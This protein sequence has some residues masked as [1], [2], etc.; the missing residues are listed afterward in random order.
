MRILLV[1]MRRVPF[2]CTNGLGGGP[3]YFPVPKLVL[4]AAAEVKGRDRVPS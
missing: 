1:P 3:L 4:K 2:F